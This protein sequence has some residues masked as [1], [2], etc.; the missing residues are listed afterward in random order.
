MILVLNNPDSIFFSLNNGKMHDSPHQAQ[1][2]IK[3]NR[4]HSNGSC[5]FVG[6]CLML[7]NPFSSLTYIY[8]T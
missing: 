2:N 3:L 1:K 7:E 8:N 5:L 6:L 4:T